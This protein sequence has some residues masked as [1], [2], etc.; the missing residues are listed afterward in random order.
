[1]QKTLKFMK[2]I[3]KN[4]LELNYSFEIHDFLNW[5]VIV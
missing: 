3:S 4:E 2:L 1:M 5:R